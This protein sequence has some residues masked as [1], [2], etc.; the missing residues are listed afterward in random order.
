LP[1]PPGSRL[2]VYEIT[3]L[4]GEGGM[5]QVYRATDT[6]LKRQVAIKVLPE[7]V[8]GDADRLARFQREAEMLAALNH[9][10]IAQIYGLEKSAGVTAL[11]ME[12]VEGD[13]LSTL[14]GGRARGDTP[15]PSG[16]AG[17][18]RGSVSAAG[19]GAPLT[20]ETERVRARS[21]AHEGS[22]TPRGGGAPRH[23]SLDDTVGHPRGLPVSDALSIARQIADA[24]EAAH[25]QGIIHRDLKPANVKVR[26]DGTVK[27][28]D[29]GLA[30]ALEPAA[31]IGAPTDDVANSPTLT[32]PPFGYGS[33]RPE[34]SRGAVLTQMGMILGTAAYMAPEQARGR[35]VDRRADI[36]AFGCVLYEMLTGQRAFPGEDVTDTLAAVVRSEPDWSILP[37]DL[38]QAIATYL[39]RC[40]HKDPRQRLQAI[41][42]MRLALEG[43]FEPPVERG[44]STMRVW[45]RPVPL[46]LAAVGLVA[47]SVLIGRQ[48]A[49]VSDTVLPDVQ[50]LSVVLPS[51]LRYQ[52]DSSPSHG[53]AVSPDGRRIVFRGS[54]GGSAGLHYRTVDA[55]E[56]HAIPGTAGGRQPFFAPD[57]S[58][59]PG[60]Q[61]G[62]VA[63]R[64]MAGVGGR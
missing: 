25:E 20:P 27:V 43:A 21:R 11:V 59:G 30:K 44:A 24:L 3:S 17:E 54:G 55:L 31:V 19:H 4:L 6:S 56:V 64:P 32:S 37:A 2:G 46:L 62:P 10:N 45:Q 53:L 7:S 8:A 13:D 60:T 58:V 18:L 9:S 14:I 61:S 15:K 47:A 12:L 57:G 48:S 41:G 35:Q 16:S 39:Q 28:L 36:W 26:E 63:R 40:L 42:D 38:P 23:S 34:Q 49:P 52:N 1:L 50:R 5:G 51:G 29:F 33:G 22:G